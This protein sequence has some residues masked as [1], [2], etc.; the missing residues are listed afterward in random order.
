MNSIRALEVFE[1]THAVNHDANNLGN[2]L[3][4]KCP[5]AYQKAKLNINVNNI[6]TRIYYES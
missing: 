6:Q 1:D 4:K 3:R 2:Y 5:L